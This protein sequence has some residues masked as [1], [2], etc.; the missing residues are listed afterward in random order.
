MCVCLCVS[1]HQRLRTYQKK[2]IGVHLNWTYPKASSPAKVS[3]HLGVKVWGRLLCVWYVTVGT[4]TARV[5]V[6]LVRR[7]LGCSE[8]QEMRKRASLTLLYRL[9]NSLAIID[10]RVPVRASGGT[11]PS[12][13]LFGRFQLDLG[14]LLKMLLRRRLWVEAQNTLPFGFDRVGWW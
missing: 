2:S 9:Y 10:Q 13:S 5:M 11:A 6:V 14:F 8:L 12:E 4:S 3:S 1:S 7:D